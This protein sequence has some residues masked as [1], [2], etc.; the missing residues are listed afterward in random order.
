MA[1]WDDVRQFFP[2]LQTDRARDSVMRDEFLACEIFSL[3]VFP[4]WIKKYWFDKSTHAFFQEVF[5]KKK[6]HKKFKEINGTIAIMKNKVKSTR[7]PAWDFVTQ[8]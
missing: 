7:S 5:I 1:A 2:A 6:L 8:N 4:L 3:W